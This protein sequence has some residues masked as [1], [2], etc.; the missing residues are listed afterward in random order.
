MDVYGDPGAA[1]SEG[2][3]GA[4][5]DGEFTEG[6]CLG[7]LTGP[8]AAKGSSTADWV[9]FGDSATVGVEATIG[10]RPK[11]LPLMIFS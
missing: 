11:G 7:P 9:G 1:F 2:P 3:A 10:V 8:C 4:L 5:G 6:P